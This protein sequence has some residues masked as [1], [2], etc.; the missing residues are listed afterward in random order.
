MKTMSSTNFK[1]N[2]SALL[3]EITAAETIAITDDK[4][5][6]IIG[7]FNFE[8]PIKPQ[9]KLGILEGTVT[10]TFGPDWE[11]TEDEFLGSGDEKI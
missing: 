9:R 1:K 2:F 6:E 3:K 11:M 4:T 10:V 5:N 7:Y 8:Q